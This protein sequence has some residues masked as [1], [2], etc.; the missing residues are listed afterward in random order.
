[1]LQLGSITTATMATSCTGMSSVQARPSS[2]QATIASVFAVSCLSWLQLSIAGH[3][4]GLVA[5]TADMESTPMGTV[6]IV[7]ADKPATDRSRARLATA[8][9]FQDSTSWAAAA[10]TVEE[11]TTASL[12]AASCTKAAAAAIE[13]ATAAATSAYCTVPLAPGLTAAA[14]AGTAGRA[15]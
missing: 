2:D 13:A 3:T 10:F 14:A 15:K 7:V 9:C 11:G 6:L 4:V 5:G 12:A 1:M 8:T